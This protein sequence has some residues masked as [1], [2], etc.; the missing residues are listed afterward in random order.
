MLSTLEGVG[1]VTS[2]LINPTGVLAS[3]GFLG[4]ILLFEI[5][6]R[7]A[8]D[9]VDD[10]NEFEGFEV[11]GLDI[12]TDDLEGD[13]IDDLDDLELE[14]GSVFLTGTDIFLLITNK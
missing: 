3:V 1:G 7:D 4:F 2:V 6:D 13:L 8:V 14:I 5:N 12:P 9:A 10:V 11:L